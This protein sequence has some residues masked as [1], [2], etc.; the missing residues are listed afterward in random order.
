VSESGKRPYV[1]PLRQNH[2][3]ATR[4]T[5]IEAAARLFA[6]RGYSTTSIDDIAAAAGVSRATVFTS[7]G[8]KPVL[9]KAAYDVAVVGDNEPLRLWERKMA[10][11]IRAEPDAHRRLARYAEL[12]TAV[13]GRVA[14]ISEAFRG[15]AAADLEVRPLWKEELAQ[16]AH[17]AAMVVDDVLA[18]G[19][20]RDGLDAAAATDLVWLLNDPG[21]YFSLVHGRGWAPARYQTWLADTLQRQLLAD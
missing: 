13:Q 10:R 18:T 21:I 3:Q 15:A 11:S 8:G 17:D 14:P 16:R 7:V 6:E 12:V 5:V 4:R 20:L 19:P 9:L 1:S 2:A